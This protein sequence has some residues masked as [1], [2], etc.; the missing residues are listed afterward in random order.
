MRKGQSEHT[1][2]FEQEEEP[3][4]DKFI[5]K[6]WILLLIVWVLCLVPIP[7][8]GSI[9]IVINLAALIM[10]IVVLVRGDT[11]H[12]VWQLLSV[13]ILTPIFYIVGAL[14]F[15]SFITHSIN[16]NNLS[17]NRITKEINNNINKELSTLYNIGKKEKKTINVPSH[18]T[19]TYS[20]KSRIFPNKSDTSQNEKIKTFYI[21]YTKEGGEVRCNHV[22]LK[23]HTITLK[24]KSGVTIEIDKSQVER[25]ERYQTANRKTKKSVWSPAKG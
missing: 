13:F 1:Q 6:T 23:N 10:A 22:K 2:W 14:I 5:K 11:R 20:H 8:T 24:T 19:K 21:T 12:G 9:A 17:K 7:F 15:A 16:I 18:P 25:I 4:Q 3:P